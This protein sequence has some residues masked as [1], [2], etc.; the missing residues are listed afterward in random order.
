M[1]SG[2]KPAKNRG[3]E[4]IEED[5]EFVQGDSIEDKLDKTVPL[6]PNNKISHIPASEKTIQ[7]RWIRATF[8]VREKYVEDL[9]NFAY[10]ERETIKNILDNVL[11]SY[12]KD[13]SIPPRKRK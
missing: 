1:S 2:Y 5:F 9:K 10:W 4:W 7:D 3:L 12:F 13:R 11:K 8:I 6:T